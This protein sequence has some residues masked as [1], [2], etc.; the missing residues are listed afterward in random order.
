MEAVDSFLCI[1]LTLALARRFGLRV[2]PAY[3]IMPGAPA[4]NRRLAVR[5][6]ATDIPVFAITPKLSRSSPKQP[7][8]PDI[9]ET[10]GEFRRV[11]AS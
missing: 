3:A 4:S 2:R 1:M 8:T 10:G 11:A 5:T 6:V 9:L 7:S